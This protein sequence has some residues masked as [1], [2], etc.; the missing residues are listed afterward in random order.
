M[1]FALYLLNYLQ[2]T[3]VW[4]YS[5]ILKDIDMSPND[6]LDYRNLTNKQSRDQNLT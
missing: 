3:I 2:K 4:L 6:K 5:K 1:I